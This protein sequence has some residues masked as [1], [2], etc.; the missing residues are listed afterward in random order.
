LDRGFVKGLVRG[1]F[2]VDGT[3]MCEVFRVVW[4]GDGAREVRE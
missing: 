2:W 3:D 4:D 1:S